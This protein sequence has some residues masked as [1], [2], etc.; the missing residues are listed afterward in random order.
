MEMFL[1]LAVLILLIPA[2]LVAYGIFFVE[3]PTHQG[4]WTRGNPLDLNHRIEKQYGNVKVSFAGWGTASPTVGLLPMK[5]T[6][7]NP[8]DGIYAI[9]TAPFDLRL[10]H[11][12]PLFDEV[13]YDVGTQFVITVKKSGLYIGEPNMGE[14]LAKFELEF[15]RD[16][17]AHDHKKK[18]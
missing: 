2:G 4:F 9:I 17:V 15:L 5:D 13:T 11:C 18:A 10:N 6:T 7:A 1:A 16:L 14:F 3:K 8:S 12:G